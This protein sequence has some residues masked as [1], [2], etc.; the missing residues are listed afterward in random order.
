MGS[1]PINLIK[2]NKNGKRLLKFL[3][4]LIFLAKVPS[5]LNSKILALI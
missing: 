1:N 5:F 4:Q 2:L 3:Q